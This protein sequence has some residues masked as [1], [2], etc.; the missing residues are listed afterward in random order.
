MNKVEEFL[1]K[2]IFAGRWLLAPLYIGLLAAL[3]PFILANDLS[4]HLTLGK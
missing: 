1:E 3:L 4:Y 2:L